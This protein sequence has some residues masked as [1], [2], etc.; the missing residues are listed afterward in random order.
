MVD[1][2]GAAPKVV[3]SPC[4]AGQRVTAEAARAGAEG[5]RTG[6]KLST[7]PGSSRALRDRWGRAGLGLGFFPGAR[8]DR[9]GLERT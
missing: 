5:A 7:L 6:G 2:S 4:L 9:A 8:K 1:G 3:P